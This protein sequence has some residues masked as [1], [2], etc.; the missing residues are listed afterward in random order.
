VTTPY[1][2]G[3]SHGAQ[4]IACGAERTADARVCAA[5]GA[6][7]NA[8]RC[9]ACMTLNAIGDDACAQCGALLEPEPELVPTE[10]ICPRGCGGLSAVADMHE[11]T[12][13]GGIFVSNEALGE[14]VMRHKDHI[15]V[16][17]R[18][19]D[20]PADHVT[21]IPCPKC[22]VRMNRTVFGKS[23][24]VIVDVCK[25]HGTWFDA[26]ELTASLAFI[27]RGGLELVAKREAE[28]K[29]EE[30]RKHEVERRTKGFD[31]ASSTSSHRIGSSD[32][33]ST[34]DTL[35]GLVEI[36]LSL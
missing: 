20:L 4:C 34:A 28:R 22:N 32:I 2:A 15:G 24:G 10:L 14:L 5:C 18:P 33:A 6:E 11:C 19:P 29:A 36:L 23:S 21:Y 27:E 8:V 13:C 30:A 7:A 9:A 31:A 12:R 1:R 35:R 16:T 25:K 17:I 3:G 26:R